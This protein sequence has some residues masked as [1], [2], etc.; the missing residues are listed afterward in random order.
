MCILRGM[1]ILALCGALA[2]G[3]VRAQEQAPTP[4]TY[5]VKSGDTLYSIAQR[6]GVSVE[7]LQRLNGLSGTTIE[8]GQTL[9]VRPPNAPVPSDTSAAP[10]AADTAAA[11]TVASDTARAPSRPAPS[12]R[13]AQPSIDAFG[14]VVP[15]AQ[16]LI[17]DAINRLEYGAYVVRP[18][19]TFYSVAARFGTTGDSLFALN[20]RRTDPLPPGQVL[21]LPPRF[22]LPSHV[23]QPRDSTLYVVASEYGVSVRALQRVNDLE[24]TTAAPGTRLR[25]PGRAAPEPAPR[26]ALPSPDARGPVA[27]YPAPFEGRLTASGTPYDPDQLVVSHPDLPFGRVVLLANAATGRRTFARVVDRGPIDEDM[28]VD[29]SAA[30]A[31]RLGLS[32][33]SNQPVALYVVR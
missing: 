5:V 1:A 3:P 16:T 27:R 13:E 19:D 6:F 23:V 30:V 25:I 31:E 9:V 26:G 18:G 28:L 32:G 22:A 20:G 4:A 2:A 14:T 33:G 7:M 29:V 8:V 17:D 15:A 10:A 24:G 12:P 11:D 21:R